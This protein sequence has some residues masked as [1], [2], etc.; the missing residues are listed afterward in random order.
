MVNGQREKIYMLIDKKDNDLPLYV[1]TARELAEYL[2]ITKS[3]IF[4]A[5]SHAKTR[6][7]KCRYV[8]IGYEDEEDDDFE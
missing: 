6:G 8:E 4:S 2:G 5:I 1:G 7:H 3:A